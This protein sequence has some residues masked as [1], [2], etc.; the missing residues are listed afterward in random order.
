MVTVRKFP[1]D[2]GLDHTIDLLKEGYLFIGNRADY[3]ASDV[4][5]TRLIGKKV[6]CMTGAASA[7]MFYNPRIFERKKVMPKRV[8]ETLIGKGGVQ[9]L[10]GKA[11]QARK[12]L[13]I[14][15]VNEEQEEKL[16]KIADEV[17]T[18]TIKA[19]TGKREIMLFDEAKKVL[20]QAA[21]EWVGVPDPLPAKQI[22]K[23][24][25]ALGATI[26]GFGRIGP[27]YWKG[28]I[29]RNQLESSLKDTIEGIRN[30]RVTVQ[31]GT[32]LEEISHYR[33]ERGNLLD[34]QI[35]AVELL[36]IIRPIVA[37][38][39]YITFAAVALYEN[40]AY[41]VKLGLDDD[42]GDN[43]RFNEEVRRYYPFAPF[44][45]AKVK[46]N[47]IW[48][49]HAFKKGTLVLLDLYGT[50]HDDRLWKEPFTF[51]PDRYKKERKTAYNF[52]PQGGGSIK[53][54]RCVGERITMA[55]MDIALDVLTK[56]ISYELPPQDLSYSM[57]S[58]PTLPKSGVIMRNIKR[59]GI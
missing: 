9:G 57:C 21:C 15:L 52:M 40:P 35:A 36:N 14:H 25:D 48:R 54:H 27:L 24:A 29:S 45:G 37:V 32:I 26:F 33:D 8:K 28:K 19:W 43:G 5:E 44:I 55:M 3:L 53:G 34:S 11:H 22:R 17:W 16:I 4:F 49:N 2:K 6:I 58:I 18:E 30:H 10:D 41:K 59:V 50:N 38:A 31:K 12:N 47:F 42:E 20:C 51:N 56:K 1:K 23:A 46:K 13:F 7:K 39:V